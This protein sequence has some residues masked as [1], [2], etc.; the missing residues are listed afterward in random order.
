MI[1]QSRGK[2][3]YGWKRLLVTPHPLT[4]FEVQKF[5]QN[6]PKSKVFIHEITCQMLY[7]MGLRTNG[8]E[9]KSIGTH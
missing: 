8:D 1:H 7:R 5:C 2:G 9:Y 4:N 6:E 3:N